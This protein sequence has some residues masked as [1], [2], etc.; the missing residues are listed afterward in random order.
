MDVIDGATDRYLYSISGLA[1][2]AGTLVSEEQDLVF[3]SNR[4]ED[5]VS[6]FCAL[7]DTELARVTVDVR[8]NGL[9][10]DRRRN[11]LLA[12]NVGDPARPKSFTASVV[13][14]GR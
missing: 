1:G 3:T 12:A 13:D 2:V 7:T 14:I 6:I 11:H 10:H 5:S 4:G 8:P 9:A